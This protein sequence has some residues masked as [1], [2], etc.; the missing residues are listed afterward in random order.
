MLLWAGLDEGTAR[1]LYLALNILIVL[2]PFILSFDRKVAFR[3][4]WIALIPAY[5]AVS[6]PFILW[7]MAMIKG[8][9]WGF[10]PEYILGLKM[11]FGI[12]VEE[13]L[14]FFTVPFACTFTFEALKVY[15][16]SKRLPFSRIPLLIMGVF[17]IGASVPFM[18]QFYT[19]SVLVIFGV[20]SITA[21]FVCP[22]LF[23]TSTFYVFL[24]VATFLFVIFN[25][26][27]TSIPI[28]WYWHGSIWGGNEAW[29][30]RF[31]TIPYEDFI[32]NFA[33]LI[34]FLAV[35]YRFRLAWT[36]NGVPVVRG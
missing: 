16:P 6:V 25:Y 14:F 10:N 26:L 5:I 13:V 33:L 3:K 22:D 34:G 24:F 7:D 20:V 35:Y 36:D 17:S 12:P 8:D 27:L 23:R 9:H 18:D 32:Y 15:V 31:M 30:G 28:V 19:A 29:N 2:F 11:A 1:F 21:P 4:R